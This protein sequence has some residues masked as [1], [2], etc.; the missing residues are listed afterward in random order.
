MP[1]TLVAYA[2]A[3]MKEAAREARRRRDENLSYDEVWCVFDVDDHP[4]IV[5]AKQQARDNG[6][7]VAVSNPCFELWILLHFQSQTRA[8][9]RSG[10]RRLC[11][12]YI[13]DYDKEAKYERLKPSYPTAVERARDLDK[14][15]ESRNTT[16]HNP[17]TSVHQLT[18]RLMELNRERILQHHMIRVGRLRVHDH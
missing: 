1:K 12:A 5:E 13:P 18:E 3:R 11:K 17:S 6:L 9:Q 4:A 7:K 15:H 2:V 8:E 10:I 16:G 14:W